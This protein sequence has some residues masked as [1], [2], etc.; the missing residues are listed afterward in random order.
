VTNSDDDF[1]FK[2]SIRIVPFKLQRFEGETNSFYFYSLSH[3]VQSVSGASSSVVAAY[4]VGSSPPPE[5]DEL[6]CGKPVNF[7]YYDHLPGVLR[8]NSHPEIIEPHLALVFHEGSNGGSGNFKIKRNILEADLDAMEK[9]LKK[10]KKQVNFKVSTSL[11]DRK[12]RQT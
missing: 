8:R 7:T 5:R 1:V 6:D 10:A 4:R 3:T 12:A 11:M 9:A 2:F